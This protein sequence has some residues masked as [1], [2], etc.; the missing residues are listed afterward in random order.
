MLNRSRLRAR[1]LV[2]VSAALTALVIAGPAGAADPRPPTSN[3]AKAAAG[4]LASQLTDGDHF[5]TSFGT[6]TFDD[7][8]LTADAIVAFAE[9]KVAGDAG[10]RATNWLAQPSVLE[11]YI[12]NGTDTTW[13]GATAKTALVA[14]VEGRNPR[15]FGGVD[16]IARLT[17]RL[18]RS[19]RF[20]DQSGFGDFSNAI[21]QSLAIIALS[22][23][24]SVP[25]S[26]AT[27]LANARCADGG[28]PV[29]FDDKPCTSSIDATGFAV[30]AL[31]AAGRT[32]AAA[33][34]VEFLLA[35]QSSDGGFGSPKNANSTGL[36]AQALRA[37]GKADAAD[38][39]LAFLRHLQLHCGSQ[40]QNRG[41]VRYTAGTFE[42]STAT[43]AT[44]QAT[45][46]LARVGLVQASS[47]GQAPE[48]AS[49]AC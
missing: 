27:F 16:L 13:A 28:S 22:R 23:A 25:P 42:P 8:G 4:W 20:T 14:Q 45:G 46:A 6:D 37:A 18:Q 5:T 36:A 9:A 3:P 24:G 2:T 38:K 30:Q 11:S 19:G 35:N 31:L 15:N 43:R 17:A 29:T 34:E 12:G 32:A 47:K 48:S 44:A 39:A 40:P 1:V 21:G 7:P 49:L 41:A 33:D 26:A 10:R